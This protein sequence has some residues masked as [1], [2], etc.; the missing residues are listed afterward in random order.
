MILLKWQYSVIWPL[1]IVDIYHI[2]MSLICLIKNH[3]GTWHYWL[4]SSLSRLLNSTGPGTYPQ[5]SRLFK[6]LLNMIVL[7]YI[8][9]LTKFG[10]LMSCGSKDIYSKM[11]PVSRTNTHHGV[12]DLVNHGMFKNTKTWISWERNITFLRN[13]KIFNL[14]LRWHILWS[15][16]FV[17]MVT[18]KY[19]V[20]SRLPK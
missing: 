15:Y 7:V 19:F 10:D 5:S 20:K 6:R 13:K 4:L 9:Q 8:Y 2:K 16:R 14:C 17:A 3:L 18:C 1:L 11:Y 12:I